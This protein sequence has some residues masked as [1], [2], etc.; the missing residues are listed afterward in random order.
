M[1]GMDARLY[2]CSRGFNVSERPLQLSRA[3]KVSPLSMNRRL[4]TDAFPPPSK[5]GDQ[6]GP[7]LSPRFHTP[8]GRQY[9]GALRIEETPR[10]QAGLT[11]LCCRVEGMCIGLRMNSWIKP[12]V[13]TAEGAKGTRL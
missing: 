9:G 5:K 4:T 12:W 7:T 10:L 2:L 3:T 1:V 8:P 11:S 13:S 6:E